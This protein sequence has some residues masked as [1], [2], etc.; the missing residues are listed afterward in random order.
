VESSPHV[1]RPNI[2]PVLAITFYILWFHTII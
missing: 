2:S 1:Y